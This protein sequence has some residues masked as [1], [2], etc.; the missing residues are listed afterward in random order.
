MEVSDLRR[1][2]GAKA[3]NS[4]LLHV[5]P[6]C[7]QDHMRQVGEAQMEAPAFH[8][9]QQRS[10]LKVL[11]VEILT[12]DNDPRRSKAPM[13]SGKIQGGREVLGSRRRFA[14]F[15]RRI[16]LVSRCRFGG[17]SFSSFEFPCPAV[18][19]KSNWILSSNSPERG[20]W[21][22]RVCHL[23][24]RATSLSLSSAMRCGQLGRCIVYILHCI[25]R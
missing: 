24:C 6:L 15:G 5:K 13:H 9:G 11:H 18:P 3:E 10:P 23:R 19:L 1:R 21:S 8:L 25:T 2:G 22:G 4:L 14:S 16:G 7:Q 20:L 17:S 12:D